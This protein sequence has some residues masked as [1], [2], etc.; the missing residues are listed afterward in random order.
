MNYSSS[1]NTVS[2]G[3]KYLK[4]G[5]FINLKLSAKITITASAQ[6]RNCTLSEFLRRSATKYAGSRL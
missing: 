6:P 5:K 1:K 2:R 4:L 3:K